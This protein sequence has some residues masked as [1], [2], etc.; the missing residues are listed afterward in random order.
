MYGSQEAE[1]GEKTKGRW[2]SKKGEKGKK[3]KERTNVYVGFFFTLLFSTR[4]P[5]P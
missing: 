4:S 3:E 5:I 1:R 2:V